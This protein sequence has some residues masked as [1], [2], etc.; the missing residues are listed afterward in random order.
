[1]YHH[2]LDHTRPNCQPNFDEYIF[3]YVYFFD[4]YKL[5]MALA[6]LCKHRPQLSKTIHKTYKIVLIMP[7]VVFIPTHLH[8]CFILGSSPRLNSRPHP[9]P[10][11]THLSTGFSGCEVCQAL[12][13]EGTIRARGV[14]IM[15]QTPARKKTHTV[16]RAKN[17]KHVMDFTSLSWF[18]SHPLQ[19]STFTVKE[20]AQIIMLPL[21]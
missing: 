5:L 6:F 7:I 18:Y 10:N 14:G 19:Q 20:T 21:P 11:T 15:P 3:E 4:T 17:P 2:W 9:C 12:S 1:M 13:S 8:S 16:I